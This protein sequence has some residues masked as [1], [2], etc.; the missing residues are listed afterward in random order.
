MAERNGNGFEKIKFL[1]SI[2]VWTLTVLVT[3]LVTYNAAA[4]DVNTRL[5]VIE[6]QH[7]AIEQR[8]NELNGRLA[9]LNHKMDQILLMSRTTRIEP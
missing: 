3:V 9:E 4:N 6:T 8:F 7:K 2:G 5:V 1:W